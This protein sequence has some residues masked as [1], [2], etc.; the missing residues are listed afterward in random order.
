MLSEMNE[1]ND[2]QDQ[3]VTVSSFMPFIGS[4]L[5][6]VVLH[7]KVH[8]I[9]KTVTEGQPIK[10]EKGANAPHFKYWPGPENKRKNN[11][12]FLKEEKE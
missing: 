7:H 12:V 5:H 4:F 9:L 10:I 6:F 11:Q 3:R 1:E 2:D 8:P